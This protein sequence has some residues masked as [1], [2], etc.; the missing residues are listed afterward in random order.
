MNTNFVCS[1]PNPPVHNGGVFALIL[2]CADNF[3]PF[4]R[5]GRN[6]NRFC[7]VPTDSAPADFVPVSL[8][9]PMRYPSQSFSP[10]SLINLRVDLPFSPNAV[11]APGFAAALFSHWCA[12]VVASLPLGRYLI[13]TVIQLW[14]SP[15]AVLLLS[16]KKTPFFKA[17]FLSNQIVYRIFTNWRLFAP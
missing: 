7:F 15:F 10:L 11:P 12:L 14:R 9:S 8:L 16:T 3:L 6:P 13:W 4:L 5:L 2:N 17:Y 1:R